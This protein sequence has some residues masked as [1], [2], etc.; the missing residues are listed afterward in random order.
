EIV[1]E[2]DG[3][4]DTLAQWILKVN[5]IS[6]RSPTVFQQLGE[7]VP[8]RLHKGAERW[9]F[10]L[11]LAY[12]QEASQDW[13][14]IREVIGAY[15]MNRSW[16]DC[17]KSRANKA[18]FRE[19]GHSSETPSE[20]FVR[21]AE[22]LKLVSSLSDSELIMEIMNGAPAFWHAVSDAQRCDMAVEFQAAIKYHEESL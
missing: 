10:S 2:W 7:I 15:Y 5:H 6:H 18:S 19:A 21:K 8:L 12:R 13:Q 14:S 16:L 22:L 11:P 1:P 3:N 4:P 9:F 17:Q 20:Y